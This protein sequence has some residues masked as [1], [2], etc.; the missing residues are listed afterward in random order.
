M[1]IL[2]LTAIAVMTILTYI[3]QEHIKRHQLYRWMRDWTEEDV[4]DCM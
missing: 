1:I 3:I 2:G 4:K